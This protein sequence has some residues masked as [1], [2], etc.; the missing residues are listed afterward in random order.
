[1]DIDKCVTYYALSCRHPRLL[2]L[3]FGDVVQIHYPHQFY[4]CLFHDHDLFHDL[5]LF[6]DHVRDL[7]PVLDRV[8]DPFHDLFVCLI[9]SKRSCNLLQISE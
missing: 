6:H 3:V 7:F 9:E 4:L 2:L 5:A 8:R 1:M